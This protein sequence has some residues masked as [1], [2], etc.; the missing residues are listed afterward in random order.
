LIEFAKVRFD[1]DNPHS[2]LGTV[3]EFDREE[4]LLKYKDQNSRETKA[5]QV[6]NKHKHPGGSV[7]VPQF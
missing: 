3:K 4:W 2:G 7:T 5:A 1:I 6:S